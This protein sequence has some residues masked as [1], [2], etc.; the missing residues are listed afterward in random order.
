MTPRI[1]R[2]MAWA[3]CL[4]LLAALAFGAYL[5]NRDVT[6]TQA[7]PPMRTVCIGRLLVDLPSDVEP[8]GY[9]T[10]YYG[11]DK[12]FDTAEV[13]TIDQGVDQAG[14]ERIV[15]KRVAEL[16]QDYDAK[17]PSK[18]RLA[19]TRK[20]DDQT[21][22]VLAHDEAFGAYMSEAWI[23]RG[24]AV[25][26]VKR[27]V[28]NNAEF[29]GRVDNPVDIEAKVL[30]LAQHITAIGDPVKTGKGTCLGGMLING[31]FDGEDFTVAAGNSRV[32]DLRVGM[33]INSFIAK[34][35]GGLLH[36]IDS[37][38]DMLAKA[39]YFT[40]TFLRK[41]KTTIEGRPA[42]E[43][44]VEAKERG[45]LFRQ[46]DAETLLLRPSSFGEAHIHMDMHMG[47]QVAGGEYVDPSFSQ[48]DSL[49]LWDAIIKSIRLRPGAL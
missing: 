32:A 21:I 44:V 42:E 11:L 45:K 26:S 38:A 36:R 33:A 27:H 41:G 39:G 1:R 20:I 25:G 9:V 48:A 40:A 8:D 3:G 49:Q 10:L 14:F 47:G 12:D 37:K 16:A 24:R 17:T 28:Y 29:G 34:S 31:D 6:P 2:N 43:L 23:L 30:A 18:N 35:D 46:F 19:A 7:L 15:A 5:K 13:Q 22:L 4:G